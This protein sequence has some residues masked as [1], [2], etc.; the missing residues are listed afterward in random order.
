MRDHSKYRTQLKHRLKFSGTLRS[1]NSQEFEAFH[2]VGYPIEEASSHSQLHRPQRH[3][4][5]YLTKPIAVLSDTLRPKKSLENSI[6]LA[7]L[8]SMLAPSLFLEPM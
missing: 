5:A 6:V 3:R 2:L 7:P 4:I 1:L 8:L